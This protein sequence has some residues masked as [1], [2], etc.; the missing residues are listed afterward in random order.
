M[1]LIWASHPQLVLQPDRKHNSTKTPTQWETHCGKLYHEWT[2]CGVERSGIFFT[3][4]ACTVP[5]CPPPPL[6]SNHSLTRPREEWFVPQWGVECSCAKHLG[7][8][9]AIFH[10]HYLLTSCCSYSWY[11]CG[12]MC[13]T[14]PKKQQPLL[15]VM[16][17]T[18][19]APW[20]LT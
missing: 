13:T 4:P 2:D 14:E 20:H 17:D 16:L 8:V 3:L 9:H 5:H 11:I 10:S 1:P 12:L 6:R 7:G 19:C 15:Q 18:T